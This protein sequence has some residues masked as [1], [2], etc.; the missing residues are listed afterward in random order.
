MPSNHPD[1]L[2]DAFRTVMRHVAA[3]VTVVTAVDSERQHGMTVTAVSSLSMEPPALLVCVNQ[4]TLL[5]DMLLRGSRFCVN[6]LAHDQAE[7]SAA[8][9]GALPPEER[10]ACGDWRTTDDGLRF[11][12]DGMASLICRNT[13]TIPYGTHTIFVG[14]VT[15][16]LRTGPEVPLLY[17]NTKY[18]RCEPIDAVPA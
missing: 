10:F 4:R 13:A 9:S 18:C 11:L 5:H 1:G 8:F 17:Q 16:V 2:P 14:E 12:A 15:E 6:V 3:T 7:V